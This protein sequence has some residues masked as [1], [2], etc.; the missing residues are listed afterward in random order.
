MSKLTKTFTL[1]YIKYADRSGGKL[2][3]TVHCDGLDQLEP[4]REL[5]DNQ[6][7]LLN[8]YAAAGLVRRIQRKEYF[9]VIDGKRAEVDEHSLFERPEETQTKKKD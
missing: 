1:Q 2:V 7:I 9:D 6:V 5:Y 3:C 4:N 8:E